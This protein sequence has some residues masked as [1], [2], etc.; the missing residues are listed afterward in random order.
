MKNGDNKKI[1]VETKRSTYYPLTERIIRNLAGR[2]SKGRNMEGSFGTGEL[3]CVI[4]Q[5]KFSRF[6][7]VTGRDFS[8]SR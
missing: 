2:L 8:R 7:H 1:K 5:C 6:V 4:E 3:K